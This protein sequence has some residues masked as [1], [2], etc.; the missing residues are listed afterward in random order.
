MEAS[1]FML[2][3][4]ASRISGVSHA[5]RGVSHIFLS[6]SC[7]TLLFLLFFFIFSFLSFLSF[8]SFFSE[9]ERFRRVRQLN[10]SHPKLMAGPPPGA[11]H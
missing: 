2:P 1:P 5:H 7:V 3:S 9:E 8:L 11:S 4:K 6:F 10:R